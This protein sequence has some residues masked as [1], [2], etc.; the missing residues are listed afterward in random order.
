MR[1]NTRRITASVL[2]LASAVVFYGFA[3]WQ[4]E[5]AIPVGVAAEEVTLT[6]RSEAR[7]DTN[8]SLANRDARA[9]EADRPVPS[10]SHPAPKPLPP[11]NTP[12]I[13]VLDQLEAEAS[14]GNARAACR[15]S[16]DLTRCRMLPEMRE[17]ALHE[18]T[19]AARE[20]SGSSSEAASARRILQLHAFI[21][22]SEDLCVGL[23]PA[24]TDHAWQYLLQ[25]AQAG[26][27]DSMLRFAIRPPLSETYFSRDIEGWT[28]Y[29]EQA[30]PLLERAASEGSS[31]AVYHLY[32][33][34]SGM[35]MPGGIEV[36]NS[37][38]ARAYAALVLLQRSATPIES[39]RM[40]ERLDRLRGALS[41]EQYRRAQEFASTLG[42]RGFARR[43]EGDPAFA[44]AEFSQTPEECNSAPD[45]SVQ[46]R[47]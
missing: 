30:I 29:R 15:L 16:M 12:V 4:F 2:V 23:E 13:E 18:V 37:D 28:A 41:A 26:H 46:G 32:R 34:Y 40:V 8:E 22:S 39:T 7:P 44:S 6:A 14:K 24:R 47:R 25:A 45:N 10:K 20:S 36:E 11:T 33:A 5:T 35:S 1:F 21:R 42:A 17:I 31:L 38:P 3:R 19:A 43:S 9:T 27:V